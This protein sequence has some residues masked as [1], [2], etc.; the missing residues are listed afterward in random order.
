M[1]QANLSEKERR[2]LL[3]MARLAIEAPLKPV[4]RPADFE[5]TPTMSELRGAFVT[6]KRSGQLRGCIGTFSSQNP[7]AETIN[8][9][10]RSAAFNDPRFAP[11]KGEEL[12]EIDLEI[13]VL[14]P[15]APIEDVNEIEVG[16]HGIYIR[17]GG[18]SGV[19]LPQ[20]ATENDWDRDTFLMKTCLKAGLG[21]DAWKD[22]DTEILIFSAEI[23][24]EED[25]E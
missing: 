11:L 13:S 20:V 17:K 4:S 7:L 12:P 8:N 10:A 18:A 6:I 5:I 23:F 19:L 15:L 1:S 25:F 21:T 24:G 9:M 16:R 3:S 22:P 14:T 2:T